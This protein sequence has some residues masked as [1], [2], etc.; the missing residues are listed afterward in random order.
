MFGVSN[1][2]TVSRTIEGVRLAREK[3]AWTFGV[4]V[5]A[6]SKLAQTAET[7]LRVNSVDNIKELPD[8]KR[9]I[10]PG[11]VTYTASMLG[12]VTAAIAIGERL[13]TLDAA[14]SAQLVASLRSVSES[15]R[16]SDAGTREIADKLSAEPYAGS[17]CRR[18]RRGPELR[19][20]LF[21]HGQMVRG[22]DPAVPRVPARGVGA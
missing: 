5:H 8:G 2:G 13:G 6:S 3:G 4:T 11:T 21:C 1:S 7:L 10:T 15:M 16:L 12:L 22:S 20:R 19:H 14:R 18:A 9:V 17:A